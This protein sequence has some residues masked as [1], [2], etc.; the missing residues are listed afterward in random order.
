MNWIWTDKKIGDEGAKMI[1]ES[2][3]INTTLIILDL[4]G[5]EIEVNEMKQK[6]C[7][8]KYKIE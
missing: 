8:S 6:E 7:K 5:D 2:L 3:K 4:C 1:S